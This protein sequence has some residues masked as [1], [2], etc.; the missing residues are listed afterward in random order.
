MNNFKQT[1][2]NEWKDTK[3]LIRNTPPLVMVFLCIALVLM[4]IF[5]GKELLNLPWLALLTKIT[6]LIQPWILHLEELGM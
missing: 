3:L 6:L 1:I 5:A 4:N 2:I